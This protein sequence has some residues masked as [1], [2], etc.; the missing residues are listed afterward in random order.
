MWFNDKVSLV[1]TISPFCS[2]SY[3]KIAETVQ[4]QLLRNALPKS[5]IKGSQFRGNLRPSL[6]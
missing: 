1:E 2:T 3:S 6:V 4:N 5:E